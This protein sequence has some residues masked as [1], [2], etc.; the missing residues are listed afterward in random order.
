MPRRAEEAFNFYSHLAGGIAA[1]V[2][3]VYYCWRQAIRLG[4]FDRL[5]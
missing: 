5:I 1:A 3:T 4:V 2:G